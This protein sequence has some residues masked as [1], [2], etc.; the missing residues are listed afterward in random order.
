MSLTEVSLASV[1]IK[2]YKYKLKAYLGVFSSLV[3]LQILGVIFSFSGSGS[4]G[5]GAYGINVNISYYS[6]DIVIFFTIIWGFIS[7]LLMTTRAYRDD[8][9]VLITNRVSSNLSSIAFMLIASIAGGIT[10]MLSGFLLKV[11]MYYV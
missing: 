1:V 11:L 4:M 7:A 10:A 2:Q 6:A 8:D 3:V 5:T 9:F